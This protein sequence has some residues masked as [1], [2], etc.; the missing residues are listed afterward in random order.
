MSILRK[1]IANR[2]MVVDT[3]AD[4]DHMNNHYTILQYLQT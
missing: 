3:K 2:L 4:M 1:C